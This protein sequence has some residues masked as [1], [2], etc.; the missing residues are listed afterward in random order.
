MRSSHLLI[1]SQHDA[2][3]GPWPA[4]IHVWSFATTRPCGVSRMRRFVRRYSTNVAGRE[5][6]SALGFWEGIADDWVIRSNSHFG[7]KTSDG[8]TSRSHFQK[9]SASP[10][11]GFCIFG[12]HFTPC[13][14]AEDTTIARGVRTRIV[15]FLSK[16]L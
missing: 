4:L 7:H 1:E 10:A 15:R 14:T 13:A 12:V 9:L 11:E 8:Q 16:C 5:P 3:P 2:S 6:E